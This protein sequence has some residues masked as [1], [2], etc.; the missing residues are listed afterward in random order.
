MEKLTS[1]IRRMGETA[2]NRVLNAFGGE[3]NRR[4]ETTQ[5]LLLEQNPEAGGHLPAHLI[6]NDG[7]KNDFHWNIDWLCRRGN[8]IYAS[9]WVL[10]KDFDIKKIELVGHDGE[11]EH[12]IPVHYGMYRSD[13]K[14]GYPVSGAENSGFWTYGHLRESEQID[15]FLD[16]ETGD[17]KL[18]RL[19]VD[20]GPFIETSGQDDGRWGSDYPSHVRTFLNH[21]VDSQERGKNLNVIFDH[22]LGG[23]ANDYRNMMIE[24]RCMENKACLLVYPSVTELCYKVEYRDRD[25]TVT[26]DFESLETLEAILSDLLVDEIFVNNLYSYDDPLQ[27]VKFLDHLATVLS[28]KLTVAVHDY[29]AVCPSYKLMNHKRNFC[30]IPSVKQCQV[31]LSSNHGLFKTFASQTDIL[32][33]RQSW[34]RCLRKANTIL[35]FSTAAKELLLQG[36][37]DLDPELVTI[38]PHEV[39]Y[40]PASKPDLDPAEGLNI[41]VVGAISYAKGSQLVA[42]LADLTAESDQPVRITVIGTTDREPKAGELNVTGPY[43]VKNLTQIIESE[44]VNLFWFP[45][46]WPE[47]FSYVTEELMHLEVPLAVYNI[48]APAER[49]ASYHRGLILAKFDVEYTLIELLKFYASV[50]GLREPQAGAKRGIANTT[51]RNLME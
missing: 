5:P 51:Q 48:G 3:Q 43:D 11:I 8:R 33:W 44:G 16:V 30:K 36:H 31:C 37:P 19:V 26:L 17:G 50:Y 23:G 49:V 27:M 47:T 22:N 42:D 10:K 32:I 45:S 1:A 34:K 2:L 20:T 18:E 24:G 4:V 21:L 25:G 9:G 41:G 40:M 35:C 13:V 46:I 12:R 14:R 6:A 39:D 38:V 15:L 28:A 29:F 7:G